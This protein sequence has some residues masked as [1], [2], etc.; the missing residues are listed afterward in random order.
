[1][2]VGGCADL[3]SPV[4]GQ[5]GAETL[6]LSVDE[7]VTPTLEALPLGVGVVVLVVLV[8]V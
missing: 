5:R 6:D 4:G 7:R 1:M 2:F 8:S 3:K